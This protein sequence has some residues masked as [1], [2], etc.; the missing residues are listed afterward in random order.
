[1]NE[2]FDAIVNRLSAIEHAVKDNNAMLQSIQRRARLSILFSLI[3][4]FV[5]IGFSLGLFYYTKPYMEQT[6]N[7]YTQI[8]GL[9]GM[10]ASSS[11]M[12]DKFQMF[13]K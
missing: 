10:T 4:W 7:M 6:L 13:L 3:K 1:M 12:L 11:D 9:T 5:I 8:S 2:E